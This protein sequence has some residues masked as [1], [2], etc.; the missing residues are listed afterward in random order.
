MDK[1][2]DMKYYFMYMLKIKHISKKIFIQLMLYNK[3]F[4]MHLMQ[5][6]SHHFLA[7]L[8]EEHLLHYSCKNIK[9]FK[10]V[11]KN[12]HIDFESTWY[13]KGKILYVH[14]TCFFS[15]HNVL[16]YRGVIYICKVD[17]HV[18]DH[19]VTLLRYVFTWHCVNVENLNSICILCWHC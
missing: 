12:Y 15:W 8:T 19:C 17:K 18:V 1:W 10:K 6:L 2:N 14:I 11:C 5:H 13:E 16:R 3:D 7:S 4:T 9:F